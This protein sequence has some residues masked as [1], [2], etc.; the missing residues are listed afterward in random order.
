MTIRQILDRFANNGN[1]FF[2]VVPKSREEIIRDKI[3]ERYS[4]ADEIAL[5]NN[6]NLYLQDNSLIQ[7]K[8]EYDEYINYRLQIKE[9]LS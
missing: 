6:Y 7:Y 5:I 4:L 3:A 9:N 1:G 8:E 2:N